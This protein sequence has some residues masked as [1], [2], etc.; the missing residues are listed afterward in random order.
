MALSGAQLAAEVLLANKS[1]AIDRALQQSYASLWHSRFDRTIWRAATLG[2][3]L[4][5]PAILGPL[6]GLAP[7][8]RRLEELL[9][10]ACYRTTRLASY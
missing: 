9:F 2:W 6:A 4:R 5:H 3:L 10:R 1:H 8:S 7:A